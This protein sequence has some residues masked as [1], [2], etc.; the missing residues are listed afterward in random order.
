MQS[1]EVFELEAIIKGEDEVP[2]RGPSSP[3]PT[4]LPKDK[5]DK[6]GRLDDA[7]LIQSSIVAFFVVAGSDSALYPEL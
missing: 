1:S 6:M 3:P 7:S 4:P 5:K 2:L